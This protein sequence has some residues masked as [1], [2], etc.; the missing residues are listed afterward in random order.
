MANIYPI[1]AWRYHPSLIPEIDQL[2]SPLFDVV[3]EK[4]REK[5]Y[6]NDKNSIHLSVPKGE[7]P[8]EQARRT[9]EKWKSEGVIMQDKFPGIY[10]YYQHFQ[11]SGSDKKYCRKGFISN[12]QIYDWDENILLRHENTMPG[13]VND[14]IDIMDQTQL[15]VSPTHGLYEDNSFLL[16]K[17]MDESM[18]CPLYETEDY[19]GVRD[20]L[21]VI[22]DAK[23]INIFREHIKEKQI[24]LADGHHR[25]AGSLAYKKHKTENNPQHTGLEGYNYHM[26]YLT[27][28]EAGDIRVLPTHR[29]IKNVSNFDEASIMQKLKV[30]FEINPVDNVTDLNEIILGKKSTFGLIFKDNAYKISLKPGAIREIK[31]D[32]PVKIKELDLTIL[33]Y[34]IIE[35]AIGIPGKVHV[36]SENIA[37]DRNFADCLVKVNSDEA[38]LAIIANEI[39]MDKIKEVCFS[40]Y[41]LPQKSSYFYPK[42]ICGFLFDSIKDDEFGTTF[43]LSL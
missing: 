20:V 38:Q 23:V 14:R 1:K 34:F 37:F 31:W 42:V 13:S 9:L 30:Q 10:V 4:Q 26:M 32:F 3:S 29:L 16:E 25:Y 7:N 24:I 35:K 36:T 33:H 43:D 6:L 19:Q 5:L 15:N 21:S 18:T 28:M 12:I 27:N 2:V 40:G 39:T 11:L 41:T 8:A 22:H 17:Y